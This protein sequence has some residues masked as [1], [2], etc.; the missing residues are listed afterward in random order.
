MIAGPFMAYV[1]NWI[2]RLG[3]PSADDVFNACS[4]FA[5]LGAAGGLL[6]GATRWSLGCP[7]YATT[8]H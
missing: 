6:Y 3:P 8:T 1:M 2:A 4:N 7:V 5:R